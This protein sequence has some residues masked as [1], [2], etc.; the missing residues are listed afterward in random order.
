M[1]VTVRDQ[2]ARTR[3]RSVTVYDR[4][5]F[6]FPVTENR[7]FADT[8]AELARLA[9]AAEAEGFRLRGLS[10]GKLEYQREVA[11][12]SNDWEDDDDY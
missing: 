12:S 11:A 6:E 3:T 8:L 9:R 1:N 2:P 7:P 5:I 4:R 10:V